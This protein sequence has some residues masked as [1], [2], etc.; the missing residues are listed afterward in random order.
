MRINF[1][2]IVLLLTSFGF[3]AA[4]AQRKLVLKLAGATISAAQ[5]MPFYLDKLKGKNIALVAN[6]SSLI[7]N[8]HLVDTLISSNINIVKIFIPEHGFRGDQ[9]AGALIDDS[10]DQKTGLPLISLYGNHKM[11]TKDDLNNVD[12]VLFDLQDVGTRFYTYISTLSY[13][14]EAC[15]REGVPLVVLDR[16]NPNGFYVDGPVLENSFTS[17]V[18]LHKVPVVYGLTIG[19]YA[20]MV[21]GEKWLVDS[22]KCELEVIKMG[23]YDRLSIDQLAVKPS[24]NL[25]NYQAIFLYPSLCFFEGTAISIGRGTDFPF[26]VFGHPDLSGFSFSFTPKKTTGASKPKLEGELCFGKDLRPFADNFYEQQPYRLNI[27]W[28]IDAYQNFPEKAKYFNNYFD[29]LAGNSTLRKQIEA[30][31]SAEEIRASWAAE[32]D[33]YKKIRIKYLLYPDFK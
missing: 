15:A 24:P 16:P 29:K 19:E 9:D 4:K 5:R 13:V 6:Q 14:M 31:L 32:L 30:G 20:L 7:G 33:L 28:I 2:L 25:P 3:S 12:V 27:E 11:P 23:N 17:F 22:L 10:K 1:V 18:G 21:N 8:T 26:Q